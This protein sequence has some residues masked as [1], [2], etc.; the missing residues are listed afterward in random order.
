[1]RKLFR[2]VLSLFILLTVSGFGVISHA[3][4]MPA[5]MHQSG[6]ETAHTKHASS[7]SSTRCAT[8]CTSAVV[9]KDDEYLSSEDNLDDDEPVVPFYIQRQPSIYDAKSIKLSGAELAVKR[10]PKIPIYILYSVFR[11]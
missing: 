2:H 9:S 11:V 4:A 7:S 10:P 8:L 5:S 6:H 3:S 1:M